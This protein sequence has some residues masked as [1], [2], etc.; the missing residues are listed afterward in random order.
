MEGDF[1]V[2]YNNVL[3]YLHINNNETKSVEFNVDTVYVRS[4]IK[5]SESGFELYIYDEL[6]MTYK[7]YEEYQDNLY[8][9]DLETIHKKVGEIDNKINQEF[10]SQ[11]DSINMALAEIL[12]V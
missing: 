10:K 8:L 11:I 12:G 3:G 7:E 5:K 6:Q 2:F 1:I 4:N 9:S